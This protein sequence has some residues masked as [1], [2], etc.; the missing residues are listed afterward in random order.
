MVTASESGPKEALV[1]QRG[2]EPSVLPVGWGEGA[3]TEGEAEW[4]ACAA[5]AQGTCVQVPCGQKPE[6]E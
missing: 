3:Q 4:H 1:C 5:G 2:E 6:G